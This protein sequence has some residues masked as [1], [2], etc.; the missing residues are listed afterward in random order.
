M[1]TLLLA[2]AL[3][4]ASPPA[5]PAHGV[6]VPGRSLA[7]VRLG[8]TQAQVRARLGSRYRL[9]DTC[10][11][12]TWYFKRGDESLVLAVSFRRGL[13]TSVFTLGSPLGWRTPEGLVVGQGIDR[14]QALYGT[15]DWRVCLGYG[16]LSKARGN[17][18]TT[19]YT[20]GDVVYGFALSRPV[21]P[22]CR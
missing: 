22:V 5:V 3:A 11:R 7:G 1:V 20:S 6:L 17:E 4:G 13:V 2:L 9:C 18:V 21:E 16:A 12:T 10:T 15:L 8:D 14:V 19:I